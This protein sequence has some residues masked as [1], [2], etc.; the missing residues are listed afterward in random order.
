MFCMIASSCDSQPN[1]AGT[2]R[3]LHSALAKAQLNW[4]TK[5]VLRSGKMTLAEWNQIFVE[6]WAKFVQEQ[7]ARLQKYGRN[8]VTTG[9]DNTGLVH[10]DIAN[11][12]NWRHAANTL[13]LKHDLG[14]GTWCSEDEP[15]RE[16]QTTAVESAG[17]SRKS[18]HQRSIAAA[19]V[20]TLLRLRA[21]P[22]TLTETNSPNSTLEFD[23]AETTATTTTAATP[24]TTTAA[25]AATP[26]TTA[27]AAAAATTTTTTTAATAATTTTTAAAAATTTTTTL[28]SPN[29]HEEEEEEEE[30]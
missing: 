19:G 9:W 29:S 4:Q 15:A 26:T 30:E 23:D 13:G 11:S 22:P 16:T 14:A 6:T 8:N 3:A 25:A 20:K 24:T 10:G 1:D 5:N 27:A 17:L 18:M 7:R 2:N 28:V 21:I 12:K